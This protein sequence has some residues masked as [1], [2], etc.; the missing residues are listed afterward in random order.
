[1]HSRVTGLPQL[2]AASAIAILAAGVAGCTSASSS[3]GASGSTASAQPVA[4]SPRQAIQLA[5]NET[6]NVNSFAA[7]MDI[8]ITSKP[9]AS[10]S[11]TSGSPGNVDMAG[12]L[13]EQLHPSLLASADFST[14]QAAGQSL[15]GGMGEI[16]TS[17]AVY[18]KLSLLTQSLHT[19]KP[20]IEV[21]LSG[22]NASTGLNLSSLFNQLQ[23]SSPLAQ[24]QLFAGATNVRTVGTST[25]DGVPVTEYAGTYS[26]SAVL[27]KLPADLR[28]QLSQVLQETGITSAQFQ[29]WVDNQHQVRKEAVVEDASAFTETVTT[30]VTSINQPVTISTPSASQ[31]T[32]LPASALSNVAG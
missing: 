23:S 13:Q 18:I 8:R 16:I 30:T 3:A 29:V 12:T 14:L 28:G 11:A 26:T 6:R 21:P 1:M 20:W 22:L 32:T 27:A 17:K 24:T 9:G 5:A 2:A 31:T 15:P 7:T 4:T 19:S 25:V 10:S